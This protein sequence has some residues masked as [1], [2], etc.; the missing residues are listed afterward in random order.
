MGIGMILMVRPDDAD[1]VTE[2]LHGLGETVHARGESEAG[3]GRVR[4]SG[5]HA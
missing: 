4:M 2:H 3:S 5:D 1:S